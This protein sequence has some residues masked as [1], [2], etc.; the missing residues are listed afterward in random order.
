MR[1]LLLTCLIAILGFGCT[2]QKK[3]NLSNFN[4]ST[5]NELIKLRPG[6]E[7]S[8]VRSLLCNRFF[9]KASDNGRSN[10]YVLFYSPAQPDP[11]ELITLLL[12]QVRSSND[13][14]IYDFKTLTPLI[15]KN[16]RLLGYGWPLYKKM[17]ES[18]QIPS[19]DSI[20]I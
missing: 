1:L 4:Q 10:I 15:F 8:E 11:N 18:G 17:R 16:Q 14:S 6:M 9:I 20:H 7:D 13:I 12:D 3:P 2:S 19:V 5:S